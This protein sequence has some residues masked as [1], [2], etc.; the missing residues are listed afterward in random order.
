MKFLEDKNYAYKLF[1]YSKS[2]QK[3][4]GIKLDNY[5]KLYAKQSEFYKIE[6]YV[7]FDSPLYKQVISEDTIYFLQSNKNG[8]KE[9]LKNKLSSNINCSS[10]YCSFNNKNCIDDIKSL[11]IDFD[12]IKKMT[13]DEDFREDK[14]ENYTSFFQNLFSFNNF[15]NNIIHLEIFFNS[16]EHIPIERT[17]FELVN[18]MKALKY[19]F[20]KNINYN[21][22]VTIKLNNLKLLYYNKIKN[23]NLSNI[24]CKK[25]KTLYNHNNDYQI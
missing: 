24:I 10:L 16:K 5:K 4:L 7:Y 19:L 18:N 20:I 23:L 17:S 12:K 11:N 2:F 25:L 3:K 13:L 21:E 9:L 6:N 14:Q 22:T 1:N 15:I 8:N